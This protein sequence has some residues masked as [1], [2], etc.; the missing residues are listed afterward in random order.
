MK[1]LHPGLPGVCRTCA[2][3]SCAPT[4]KACSTRIVR[5]SSYD[6]SSQRLGKEGTNA[7][8]FLFDTQDDDLKEAVEVEQVLKKSMMMLI[9]VSEGCEAANNTH[10]VIE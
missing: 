10:F 8:F 1:S 2:P 4:G 6:D 9:F 5:L 3:S 7:C